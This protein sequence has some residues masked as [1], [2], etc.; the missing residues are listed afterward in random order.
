MRGWKDERNVRANNRA[1]DERSGSEVKKWKGKG[2]GG[3]EKAKD[4]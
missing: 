4:D 3:N 2:K 1:N